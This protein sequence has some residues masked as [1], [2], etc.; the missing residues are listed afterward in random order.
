VANRSSLMTQCDKLELNKQTRGSKSCC[1]PHNKFKVDQSRIT[2]RCVQP[3][4]LRFAA[5][6]EA[7]ISMRESPSPSFLGALS[8]AIY[9]F[10]ES[11]RFQLSPNP[12][13]HSIARLTAHRRGPRTPKKRCIRLHYA[14][15]L[16]AFCSLPLKG[17]NQILIS[18]CR[19]LNWC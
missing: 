3:V 10:A 9:S 8:R 16:D 18:I 12:Y 1:A 11:E 2:K 7:A 13:L 6:R 17:Y 19:K 5:K 14:L 4:K 15:F